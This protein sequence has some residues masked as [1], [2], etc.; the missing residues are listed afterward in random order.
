MSSYLVNVRLVTG[1]GDEMEFDVDTNT[2]EEFSLF[3]THL[4]VCGILTRLTLRVRYAGSP[5][6]YA[7]IHKAGNR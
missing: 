1:E 2:D 3:R 7:G 6:S 5:V 4:G